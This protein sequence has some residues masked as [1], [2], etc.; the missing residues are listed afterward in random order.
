MTALVCC[1]L[2][3][4]PPGAGAAVLVNAIYPSTVS[5]GQTVQLGVWYQSSSGGPTWAKIYVKNSRGATV[6]HKDVSATTTWRYWHYRGQCG[7]RYTA[8][9]R[10]AGG[11]LRFPFRVNSQRK[12]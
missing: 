2:A 5:C 4:L 8:A 3:V 6:W 10:T 12:P 11:T 1:G 7:A 9:Y